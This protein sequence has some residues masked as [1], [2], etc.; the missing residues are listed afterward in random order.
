MLDVSLE[1][2]KQKEVPSVT[3]EIALDEHHKQLKEK[4]QVC[5][6]SEKLQMLILLPDTW[7]QEKISK[8]FNVSEYLVQKA[9]LFLEEI[10]ACA[11]VHMCYVTEAC[12]HVHSIILLSCMVGCHFCL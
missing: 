8:N 11:A 6:Y 3:R 4:L 9:N 5:G 10:S 12:D 7:S 1:R 2:L